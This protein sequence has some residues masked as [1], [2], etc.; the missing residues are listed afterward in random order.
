VV[1]WGAS[2]ASATAAC[3]LSGQETADGRTL[4]RSRASMGKTVIALT[5]LL[6]SVGPAW[7]QTVSGPELRGRIEQITD[8]ELIVRGGD[9]RL[10]FV[11]TAAIPSAELGVLNPGDDV[12]ITTKGDGARGPIGRS[13]QQRWPPASPER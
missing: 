4:A 8:S 12:V 11:D 5:T 7:G 3:A 10:H 6:V 13:V 1:L 2:A 9:G